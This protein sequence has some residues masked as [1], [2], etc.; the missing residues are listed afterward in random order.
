MHGFQL[1]FAWPYL[2]TERTAFRLVLGQRSADL[3]DHALTSHIES[4]IP[5]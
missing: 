1:G 4:M 2:V 5:Q 3:D